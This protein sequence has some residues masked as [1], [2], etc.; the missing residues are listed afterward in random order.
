MVAEN[1]LLRS[2]LAHA[3]DATIADEPCYGKREYVL[4]HALADDP[5]YGNTIFSTLAHALDATLAD[6]TSGS[7]M[8]PS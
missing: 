6:V 4:A 1:M 5:C 2:T 7:I 3:L 8:L